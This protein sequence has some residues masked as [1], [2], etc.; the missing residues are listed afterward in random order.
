M[1]HLGSQ[2]D[3]PQS[4]FTLSALPS[5]LSSVFF[6]FRNSTFTIRNARFNFHNFFISMLRKENACNCT[7]KLG[8]CF[9]QFIMPGQ[10]GA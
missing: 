1:G 10:K 7:N 9:T 4:P 8:K 3:V 5:P 6:H 2:S